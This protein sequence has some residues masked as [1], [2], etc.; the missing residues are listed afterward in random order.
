M[1]STSKEMMEIIKT[2]CNIKWK[3]K[4]VDPAFMLGVR[5]ALSTGD[6]WSMHLTQTEYIEGVVGT[7]KQEVAKHFFQ[8]IEHFKR[9]GLA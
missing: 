2:A 8:R 5:R 6:V 3:V 9:Q 7:W 1:A 4:E